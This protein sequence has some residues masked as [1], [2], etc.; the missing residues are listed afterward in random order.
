[1]ASEPDGD[2][3]YGATPYT[4]FTSATGGT[5]DDNIDGLLEGKTLTCTYHGAQFN[6]ETG[7]A[8]CLPAVDGVETFEVKVEDD[9]IYVLIED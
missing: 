2:F 5:G 7:K 4:P 1:M 6:V 3:D 8:L 9:D